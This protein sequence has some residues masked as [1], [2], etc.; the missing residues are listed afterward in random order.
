[1]LPLLLQNTNKVQIHNEFDR[2]TKLVNKERV[3]SLA[4]TNTSTVKE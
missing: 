4:Y 2:Y 1:M 3:I